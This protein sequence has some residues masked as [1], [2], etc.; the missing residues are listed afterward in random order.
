MGLWDKLFHRDCQYYLNKCDEMI[1][2]QDFGEAMACVKKA[3]ALAAT[4]EEKDAAEAKKKEL[5]HLIYQRAYDNAKKYLKVGNTN[6][7]Q[8]AFDLAARHAQTDEERDA[9]NALKE[10]DYEKEAEDKLEDVR[11]EGEDQVHSLDLDDKWNLYVSSLSFEKAQHCDELGKEFK[12]AWVALQEGDLN[13]AVPGLEAVYKEHE[14]DVLVM[15]ELSRAY[16]GKGEVNKA[17]KL[18]T[19]ADQLGQDVDVKL[20]RVEALWALKNFPLAEKVLQAAYDM[21]EDNVQIL[22]RIAQHGLFSRDFESGIPAAEELVAR[23]PQDPSV[24]GLAARLYLESGDEDKALASYE[25]VN[26][27]H[28]QVNPQTKKLSFNQNAAMAAAA[29]YIKKNENLE[30]AVELLEAMRANTTGEPHIAV[31]LQLA[32]VFE[33]LDKKSKRNDILAESTRFLDDML[34]ELKGPERAMVQLQYSEICEKLG[35]KDK[36]KTMIDDARAFFA[37]DAEKGQPVAAFYVELIDKKLAGEPFP[38]AGEMKERM[39]TFVKENIIKLQAMQAQK[40]GLDASGEK[41][42]SEAPAETIDAE[43]TV[44]DASDAAENEGTEAEANETEAAEAEE[45]SDSETD[46]A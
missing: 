26:K 39:E 13:T 8:N 20:L 19:K 23:L 18:L 3:M 31:C 43:A 42:Y 21:D 14:N 41:L 30:R 25:M 22:V 5:T 9:L 34:E 16:L 4:Q 7:A 40:A 10:E 37:A 46:K 1:T 44:S 11:V 45:I 32:D 24:H 36:E 28:W 6:A 38:T 35:D 12:A 2:K 17:E 27:L 33:K 15:T 29:I